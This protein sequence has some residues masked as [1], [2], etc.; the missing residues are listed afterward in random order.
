MRA[1]R[2]ESGRIRPRVTGAWSEE[3]PRSQMMSLFSARQLAAW[4]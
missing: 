3:R 1:E 4:T 2:A